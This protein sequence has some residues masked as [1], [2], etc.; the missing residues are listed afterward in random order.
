MLPSVVGGP[1]GCLG[2]AKTFT[3]I[4]WPAPAAACLS[5]VMPWHHYTV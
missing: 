5:L 2:V 1:G 3:L 4:D